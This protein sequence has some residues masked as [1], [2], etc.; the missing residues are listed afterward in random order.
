MAVQ[1]PEHD[2]DDPL[3]D[4]WS[5]HRFVWNF[6]AALFFY[7][8]IDSTS[9]DQQ[10]L[11]WTFTHRR[12]RSPDTPFCLGTHQP[13]RADLP[14]RRKFRCSAKLPTIDLPDPKLCSLRPTHLSGHDTSPSDLGDGVNDQPERSRIGLFLLA[15]RRFLSSS[16]DFRKTQCHRKIGSAG[17]G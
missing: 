13:H 4:S 16:H 5:L 10:A 8:P 17:V 11:A 3:E 9:S 15:W 2:R 14:L 6:G 1:L 12:K 7:P